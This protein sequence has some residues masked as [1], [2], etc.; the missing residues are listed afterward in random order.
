MRTVKTSRRQWLRNLTLLP[1]MAL[2]SRV[3]LHAAET[4]KDSARDFGTVVGDQVET[5]IRG[6]RL[7]ILP[8]GALEHHG[9][10]GPPSTDTLIAAGLA[11]RIAAR[12]QAA[13]FPAVAYA[14]CP[15]HTAGFHGSISVRPEVMTMLYADILRGIVKNGFTKVLLLNAHSG[16]VGPARAAASEVAQEH[17]NAQMIVVN[18]W[19]T[20]GSE[21]LGKLQLFTSG[22]GGHGHG[23]PLELSVA[24]VF[25]P[26][27]VVPGRAPDLPATEGVGREFPYFMDKSGAPG[28]KAYSG[29]LSEISREKGDK[30]AGIVVDR[31]SALVETWL[32]SDTVLG[33]W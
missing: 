8:L 12:V 20:L 16:N 6:S 3:R 18:W 21:T 15:A 24:A 13:V 9:P 23:G 19:E 32:R 22:N 11:G 1:A 4:E 27:S 30:L 31:I 29:K 14:Q 33:N 26:A 17:S 10:S 7:A 28:W 25:A 2:A 5:F